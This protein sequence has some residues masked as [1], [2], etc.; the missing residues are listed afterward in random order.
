MPFVLKPILTC[1]L[2]IIAAVTSNPLDDYVA[3]DDGLFSYYDTGIR[4][5]GK[6][7]RSGKLGVHW[8]ADVV[9]L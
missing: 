8:A 4:M 5:E 7:P 2:G 9:L 6:S 1:V 3:K